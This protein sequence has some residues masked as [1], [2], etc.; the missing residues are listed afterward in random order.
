MKIRADFVTNSSSS[1]Y[2]TITLTKG[3]ETIKGTISIFYPEEPNI[4][5]AKEKTIRRRIKKII[6]SSNTAQELS[7]GLLEAIGYGEECGSLSYRTKE[8]CDM[9]ESFKDYNI[10]IDGFYQDEG[11]RGIIDLKYDPSDNSL[12]GT[13]EPY[14]DP[15]DD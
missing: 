8:I 12:V 4:F 9:G 13:V 3:E 7:D 6:T 10:R 2:V 5:F 15:W 1:S 11:V 14:V